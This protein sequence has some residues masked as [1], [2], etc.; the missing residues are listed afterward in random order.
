[1]TATRQTLGRFV[2]QT[3]MLVLDFT[4]H[5]AYRA[6]SQG[7]PLSSLVGNSFCFR[8]SGHA[9]IYVESNETDGPGGIV[10]NKLWFYLDAVTMPCK[11]ALI[12]A[13]S[14]GNSSH[15]LAGDRS[16]SLGLC[17]KPSQPRTA[18]VKWFRRLDSIPAQR[19]DRKSLGGVVNSLPTDHPGHHLIAQG[20]IH[21]FVAL[22]LRRPLRLEYVPTRGLQPQLFSIW[23]IVCGGHQRQIGWKNYRGILAAQT[24]GMAG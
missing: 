9:Y 7:A 8:D 24:V 1:M 12:F 23:N 17:S 15:G 21:S 22:I 5:F 4:R 13:K 14:P 20:R 18:L 19:A 6:V 10:N 11:G 3:G 2:E 16:S